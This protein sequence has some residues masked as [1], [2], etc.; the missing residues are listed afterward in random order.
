MQTYRDAREGIFYGIPCTQ[1]E[2][3]TLNIKAN[4]QTERERNV[5][6]ASRSHW[7]RSMCQKYD[8]VSHEIERISCASQAFASREQH[9]AE[10]VKEELQEAKKESKA[11]IKT[12]KELVEKIVRHDKQSFRRFFMLNRD[13]KVERLKSK[14]LH[15]MGASFS[16]DAEI[17]R[18]ERRSSSLRDLR[19]TTIENSLCPIDD[20]LTCNQLNMTELS[21]CGEKEDV[22]LRLE[23]LEREKKEL[24]CSLLECLP[25]QNS[26]HLQT[27]LAIC[28]SEIKA[29]Q[30]T[31]RQLIR[32]EELYRDATNKLRSALSDLVAPEYTGTLNEF[33]TRCYPLAI[34][35]GRAM[36]AAS[37]VVQPESYRRYR[38]YAPEIANLDTPKFPQAVIDYARRTL[39][40]VNP[41]AALAVEGMRKLKCAESVLLNMQRIALEKLEVIEAW[42]DQVYKDWL[43]AE[44]ILSKLES[45]SKHRLSLFTRAA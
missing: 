42:H 13:Q 35:A 1:Q 44:A 11:L 8:R 12:Q 29:C 26:D 6:A 43:Q 30:C 5:M 18:L 31:N 34:E 10:R 37:H 28:M 33:A 39:I 27:Q 21:H 15:K 23:T 19:M 25:V 22:V 45:K 16:V 36:D 40:Y 32:I 38:K 14:L 7:R 9:E 20:S 3:T 2:S 17:Q 4:A 24:L 41:N